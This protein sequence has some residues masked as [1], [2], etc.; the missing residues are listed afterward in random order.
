M[1]TKPNFTI[2]E[3]VINDLSHIQK[4][5]LALFKDQTS[6]GDIFLDNT[7]SEGQDG[8]AYFR[9]CI[10]EDDQVTF[11]AESENKTVGYLTG[12]PAEFFSWRPIKRSELSTLYVQPNFRNRRVGT[13]LCEAFIAW[14]KERGCVRI[15]VKSYASNQRAIAFYKRVGFAPYDLEMEMGLDE[16]EG[17]HA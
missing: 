16:P 5:S 14:S 7:W 11:V 10:E 12:G 1:S 13:A 8:A 9:S 3:A 17:E 6:T 4:L 15:S 2:R